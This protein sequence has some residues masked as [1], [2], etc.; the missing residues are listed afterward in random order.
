MSSS[1]MHIAA[2]HSAMLTSGY[3]LVEPTTLGYVP[4]LAALDMHPCT[5][6][7]L[8]HREELM[9]RLIDLGSLDTECRRIVTEHWH[10]EVDAERPPV[11]CAWIESS[12][13]VDAIATHIARYLVGPDASGQPVFWRH[14]DPRVFALV[15]A[16]FSA[17]QRQALLG[18]VHT[19]RFPWAGHIWSIDGPGVESDPTEQVLGWPRIDQWPRI[20]RSEIVDRIRRRFSGFAV[21]QAAR[22][23]SMADGFLNSA[24]AN[25]NHSAN[26][27]LVE[28]AWQYLSSQFES[29]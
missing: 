23:P 27:E 13:D 11:V 8:A 20:S 2:D 19:W 17:D 15:L 21:W 16:I 3:L 24:A 18:P 7:A 26:D 22:F 6:R 5:P 28:S 12:A 1:P 4:D 9:P 14:Y 25:G 10:A 29:E